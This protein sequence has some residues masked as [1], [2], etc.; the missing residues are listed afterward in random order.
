VKTEPQGPIVQID[1]TFTSKPTGSAVTGQSLPGSATSMNL[2]VDVGGSYQVSFVGT[3]SLGNVSPPWLA[4][5]SANSSNPPVITDITAKPT[6]MVLTQG[7]AAF[8]HMDVLAGNSTDPVTAIT[9]SETDPLGAISTINPDYN[10][11]FHSSD[12]VFGPTLPGIYT[13]TTKATTSTGASASASVSVTAIQI[14]ALTASPG[15]PMANS[16]LTLTVASIGGDPSPLDVEWIITDS[17]GNQVDPSE[18]HTSGNPIQAVWSPTCAGQY[19]VSA[20]VNDALIG[21]GATYVGHTVTVNLAVNVLQPSFFS[22][23][24]LA[25]FQSRASNLTDPNF[26]E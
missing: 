12:A 4:N 5:F 16:P 25:K 6:T 15:V 19:A 18:I 23:A 26:R 17:S 9:W 20:T 3:D 24:K 11:I 22:N 13:F 7:G 10:P 21:T 8:L 14:G 1:V 2:T